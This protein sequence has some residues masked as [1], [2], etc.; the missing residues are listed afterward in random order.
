MIA[1]PYISQMIHAAAKLG[2]ADELQAGPKSAEE[3][4]EA[5]RVHAPSLYRLLRALA[6]LGL[7]EEDDRG[8]FALTRLGDYLRTD[9][10]ESARAF[11]IVINEPW[12]HRAW[13]DLL[14]S[15]QTG[16][17]AFNHAHGVG[18]WD[19]LAQYPDQ[20]ALFD[21]AMSGGSGPRAAAL[22]G[23]RDWRDVGTLVDV[24]GGN[25]Q[26]LASVLAA[27]PSMRGVVFDQEQVVRDAPAV[28]REAGVADR[29]QIVGGDFFEA[30]P[31]GGDAY[32]LSQ[33]IHDWDDQQALA[34][35]RTCRRAMATGKRL[36][37]IE[38]VI[39]GR[40]SPDMAKI[41]DVNMLVLLGG[42]QRTAD[43]YAALF[44]AAGFG[45]VGVAGPERWKIVEG[46]AE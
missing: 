41:E 7:F 39:E 42:R 46:I 36:L 11:A 34:I 17:R 3:I 13:E 4:A 43:E 44:R 25:G 20:G 23:A 16:E 19:Y 22:L 45:F 6:S 29:C 26:L 32:I 33:I 21:S 24:G 35:L 37:L 28:L 15:I 10:P 2:V 9:A 40:N 14:Y 31:S 30:V 5:L 18:F 12:I 8:R 38:Q 27:H 1:A